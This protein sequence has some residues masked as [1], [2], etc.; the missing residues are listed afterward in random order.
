LRKAIE[1]LGKGDVEGRDQFDL[2]FSQI[3]HASGVFVFYLVL[4]LFSGGIT[5]G[6]QGSWKPL[7][8]M[9]II[10]TLALPGLITT[11]LYTVGFFVS[12]RL[13]GDGL[14][15]FKSDSNA[16]A[17]L[18][19]VAVLL[20]AV[21]WVA[22]VANGMEDKRTFPV[23][24]RFYKGDPSG[25][26]RLPDGPGGDRRKT[27]LCAT[28]VLKNWAEL[29]C[30]GGTKPKL[31]VVA[32]SGGA[33]RSAVW[34]SLVLGRIEERLEKEGI[35]FGPAVRI[36]T[37]ASGGML[38]AAGYVASF[39]RPARFDLEP[40]GR[41]ANFK[42]HAVADKVW[43][44][45]LRAVAVQTALFDVPSA[46]FPLR[47]H[48]DRGRALEDTWPVLEG[49]TVGELR[50]RER[51][52][53]IPSLLFS[54]MLVEDGR[55]L[56]ISNL[57]LQG[58]TH[59]P[60]GRVGL[61]G[62]DE[63]HR[64]LSRSAVEL[65]TLFPEDLPQFR[66]STAVRMSASFPL[67]SPSV[68]LPTNPPRTVVDAGYYDNF[69]VNL[70]CDWIRQHAND[71]LTFTSGVVLIQIRDHAGQEELNEFKPRGSLDRLGRGLLFLTSPLAGMMQARYA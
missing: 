65:S 38:G 28:E 69:G 14:G 44:E 15:A 40:T 52:G 45:S 59:V 2:I 47:Q 22:A 16:L 51:T 57:D 8:S 3:C 12:N 49:I 11:V 64:C 30:W 42:H 39:V 62:D 31:A 53:S 9:A 26:V 18:T 48:Y 61:F 13:V 46:F 50:E 33:M 7:S 5:G 70:A 17:L 54:P 60:A 20:I 29:P 68:C 27:V 71:L 10:F 4:R 58:L 34:T 56:L 41:R 24:D 1:L 21:V 35:P 66:V 36:I 43:S 37:G 55:R 63:R 32:V 19:Q 6:K 25:W 23:I 67:I